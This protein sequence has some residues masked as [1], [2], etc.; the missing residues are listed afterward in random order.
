[1]YLYR[2]DKRYFEVGAEI[3]PQTNFEQYMDEE[4]MKVENIL[5]ANRSDQIPLRKDCL[6]LFFELSAALNFF[7][8]YGGYVYEVE[9]DCHDIYHRGDMNKLDNLLDLVRFTDEVDILTAAGNEYWKGGT[10]TFMP[11]YEFLVKSCIVRKCLVEPSEL[12]SFTDNFEITKSIE[13]TDLY[14]HTLENINSPL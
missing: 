6:F 10:H 7:R 4:S 5:N 8:K 14:L 12:K 1:M 13:R 2:V 9:V 3:Q 11:C